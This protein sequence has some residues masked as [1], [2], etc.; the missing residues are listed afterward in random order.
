MTHKREEMHNLHDVTDSIND[1]EPEDGHA[2]LNLQCK[3]NHNTRNWSSYIIMMFNL[4]IFSTTFT[5]SHVPRC[6]K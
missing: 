2:E 6:G 3:T 1:A 5:L 4:T